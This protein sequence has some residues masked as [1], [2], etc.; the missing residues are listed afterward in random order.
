MTAL[1]GCQNPSVTEPQRELSEPECDRAAART[2]R[3]AM[4][5]QA[6]SLR[7]S[8]PLVST[9]KHSR[10]KDESAYLPLYNV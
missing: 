8:S 10:R 6:T 2:V 5:E 7:E 3:A 1:D 4:T 9:K